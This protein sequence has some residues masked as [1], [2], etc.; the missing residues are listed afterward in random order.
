MTQP[1]EEQVAARIVAAVVE[2]T[3]RGLAS[4]LRELITD[5]ALP[6][7]TKLP[8]VR[9]LAAELHMSASTVSEAWRLLAREGIIRSAGRNGTV[10]LRP[11]GIDTTVRLE[12]STWIVGQHSLD[13]STG[14]PD[15]TLLPSI[16]GALRDIEF[17]SIDNYQIGSILPELEAVVRESWRAA[18]KPERMTMTHG[19]Y[20]GVGEVLTALLSA[21]DR[22]LVEHPSVPAVVDLVEMQGAVP[23][24]VAIDDKGILPQALAS[25]LLTR[26]AVL[27]L[28]P[29]GQNPTGASMTWGRAEE[30]AALLRPTKVLVIED[31]H[32]GAV[33][34][35]EQVSLARWLP[36]R[37]VRIQSFSKSHGPDLRLA[38]MGA[39]R[40]IMHKVEL[41]RRLN[42]GWE[43]L[44]LQRVLVRLLTDPQSIH[45]INHARRTY[46]LR[47]DTLA[48]E[49]RRHGLRTYG[50]DGLNLWVEVGSENAA[51][52]RLSEA[53]I[54]VCP[55]SPL[56]W[57]THDNSHI[58][59]TTGIMPESQA[60]RIAEL[61]AGTAGAQASA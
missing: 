49:C 50:S 20:A 7:G 17:A 60:P 61:L 33:S 25:A 18:L 55:G 23:V 5:G 40:D 43:S 14:T 51:L 58:R 34:V 42:G 16:S 30:L 4:A 22:V 47:L 31:D 3:P 27:I 19:A 54:G 56:M 8:T 24:A 21:G 41:R 29:R 53:D 6:T 36:D 37:V 26:P 12:R 45:T 11:R 1:N 57:D 52:R 28:Q 39:S 48:S 15:S 38:A 9:S 46:K 10:V 35:S 13:L 32:S 59:V 44:L 2:S